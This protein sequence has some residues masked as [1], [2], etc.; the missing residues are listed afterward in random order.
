MIKLGFV[1]MIAA[2]FIMVSAQVK[3]VSNLEFLQNEL[4]E[5]WV[6]LD[7]T[8]FSIQYPDSL[9]VDTSG[10][11]GM[12]FML[13]T[14]QASGTDLFMENMNLVIE[15]LQ[16]YEITLDDYVEVSKT[17]LK[18]YITA[19]KPVSSKRITVDGREY[20]KLIF[21]GKQGQF[22]LK[23]QQRYYIENGKAFVLTTTSEKD[24]YDTYSSVLGKVMST[25]KIK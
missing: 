9:T 23:W 18:Q 15:D 5:D 25:F 19:L 1:S 8:D 3:S 21:T 4:P 7:K 13:F 11:M 22:N 20:H 6:K 24:Q 16:G 14:N 17:Q 2:L 10:Q 12:S